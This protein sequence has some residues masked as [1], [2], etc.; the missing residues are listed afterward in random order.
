MQRLVFFLVVG[1]LC[2]T[3]PTA[4]AADAPPIPE[5]FGFYGVANGAL[6]PLGPRKGQGKRFETNVAVYLFPAMSVTK[7][8]A[9]HFPTGAVRFILFDAAVA[10]A[11]RTFTLFR[12]PYA[13]DFV[14]QDATP[15]LSQAIT[16]QR[17]QSRPKRTAID[18]WVNARVEGMEIALLSKPVPDKPQMIQMVPESEL[19]PGLYAV[20]DLRQNNGW[21]E[22]FVVGSAERTEAAPYVDIVFQSGGFGGAI[23]L[24]DYF[25]MHGPP[26]FPVLTKDHCVPCKPVSEAAKSGGSTIRIPETFDTCIKSG[27]IA[28]N[29]RHYDDASRL[30]E[31]AALLDPARPEAPYHLGVLALATG[32][33]DEAGALWDKALKLGGEIR[34]PVVREGFLGM[35]R[36]ELSLSQKTITFA[37]AQK[38]VFSLTPSEVIPAGLAEHFVPIAHAFKLRY[39]GKRKNTDSFDLVPYGVDTKDSG[40]WIESAEPGPTQQRVVGKYVLDR[41]PKLATGEFK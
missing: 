30:F 7:D 23:D 17:S 39:S 14:S 6:V 33:Y 22:V 1:L 10:D 24:H 29:R 36:G 2:D 9:P 34:F 12:L 41:I 25:L 20:A 21:F 11:S 40:S 18:A 26:Q 8:T 15:G 16:G 38:E 13:R 37:A 19:A 5:Y 35:T 28:F 4:R 31:K 32:K 3:A 27:I